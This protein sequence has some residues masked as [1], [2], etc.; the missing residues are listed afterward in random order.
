NEL[1]LSYYL[2]TVHIHKL[3]TTGGRVLLGAEK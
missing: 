3:G 1:H 2:S